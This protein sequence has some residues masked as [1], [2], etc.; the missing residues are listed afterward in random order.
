MLRLGILIGGVSTEH[1]ISI[2]TSA[3]IFKTL[4]KNKYKIKPIYISKDGDWLIPK[5]F[6]NENELIVSEDSDFKKYFQAK[7]QPFETTID[8]LKKDL[9]CVVLG[10]H[11]GMGENGFVQ[12]LLSTYSIPFTG[13]GVL[14]SALAMDK[15]KSNHLFQSAGFPVKTFWDLSKNQFYFNPKI[16]D[17]FKDSDFPL[18]VKPTCGGSSVGTGLVKN[19]TDL[20]QLL[21]EIFEF[22]NRA[23][24]QKPISGIE[25]SCGVV[26]FFK[27]NQFV[28]EALTP[29]EILPK[30][31]FFDF[32]SKYKVGGSEE[33]TP[34]RLEDNV[35]QNVK[36]LSLKAHNLLGCSGYSRT[37]FI[38]ENHIPFI[39]ET[40]TLPG[41]TGTSLIP[42]QIRYAGYSM[43]FLLDQLIENAISGK[44]L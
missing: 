22:E 30:G 29:T 17:Q 28:A 24:I 27:N 4:N 18:F 2:K 26:E 35:L 16:L 20:I 31:E 33:I 1:N 9:D 13:S 12:G 37:D 39:L 41:M 21:K 44:N 5:D 23:L 7:F 32:T 8:S 38:I 40:N 14:A 15:E 42:Q 43:E 3:F 6:S 11:G 10:L 34:A 25:V 19:K 36:E